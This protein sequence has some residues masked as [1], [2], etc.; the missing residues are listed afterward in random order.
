MLDPTWT[1]TRQDRFRALM[2]AQDLDLIYL[3]DVRDIFYATGQLLTVPDPAAHFPALAALHTDGT[4]WLVSHTMDGDA[5]VDQRYSYEP[6]L[7]ATMNPDPMRRLNEVVAAVVAGGRAPKRSGFQRE[8]ISWL[9]QDTIARVQRPASW[10]P[11]DTE[12]AAMQ[13][14]KDPDELALM[15]KAIACS[16]AAYAAAREVIAPGVSEL[17]VR[18]TAHRAAVLEAGEIIFHNG[19]YRSGVP[20]G[21]ARD[22]KIEAGEL[23]II[24]AWS[25]YRGYWSDLSRAFAVSEPTVIQREIYDYVAG[26]LRGVQH[27]IRPGIDGM[28]LWS[29]IDAR[30][31]EHP[32][33]RERGLRGHGGH[34]IGTRAH[35]QPDIN[36]DRGGPIQ[37]GMVL[38]VEPS[39]YSDELNAGVRLENQFLVTETG[40]QLLSDI[41]L[42]L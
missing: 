27:E 39:G 11:I 5:L 9:L 25:C 17:E 38:C 29:W 33:L 28:E 31:R 13:A 41:P 34:S 42:T 10:V 22:R 6:A 15:K 7:S 20:G 12:L 21:F 18:E 3:T 30:L 32:H 14:I 23:Y 40:A 37:A 1:R 16:T 24:D 26:V 8:S 2:E 4:S 35:E 19:D 36:R